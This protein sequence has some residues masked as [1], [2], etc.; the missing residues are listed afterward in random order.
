MLTKRQREKGR[1]SRLQWFSIQVHL[2]RVWCKPIIKGLTKEEKSSLGITSEK[3]FDHGV[4][5]SEKDIEIMKTFRRSIDN[6]IEDDKY[7]I[8]EDDDILLHFKGNARFSNV[9]ESMEF[10][11]KSDGQT[12]YL[13]GRKKPSEKFCKYLYDTL[14]KGIK[15][16][17]VELKPGVDFFQYGKYPK[18]TI[19]RVI[20]TF[21]IPAIEG[22]EEVRKDGFVILKHESSEYDYPLFEC[23]FWKDY[24]TRENYE[25]NFKV[26]NDEFVAAL[27]K[28]LGVKDEDVPL[29]ED[30]V[31]VVLEDEPSVPMKN[32]W[33]NREKL[34]KDGKYVIYEDDKKLIFQEGT[35]YRPDYMLWCKSKIDGVTRKV[36]RPVFFSFKYLYYIE[37]K[38][39]AGIR[40]NSANLIEGV[41]FRCSYA[42]HK[43]C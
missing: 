8:Y 40:D 2:W 25:K 13:D 29:Y 15:D 6:L 11:T 21:V 37:K 30:K 26:L 36:E 7:V 27:K 23:S 19:Y 22:V 14:I 28:R 5:V 18:P 20:E 43:R 1:Q 16:E 31:Y 4:A 32:F 10:I 38:M 24:G 12:Q 42:Y 3:D 35:G 9:I 17:S 34:L 33:K 39:Y 41:D